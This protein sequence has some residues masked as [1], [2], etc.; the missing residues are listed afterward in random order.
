MA[1]RNILF[2]LLLIPSLLFA[3]GPGPCTPTLINNKLTGRR[4]DLRPFCLLGTEAQLC[5]GGLTRVALEE[6]SYVVNSSQGGG[7]KDT[8]VM[9]D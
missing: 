5:P 3:Q 9:S 2:L 4:V 7:V 1:V 6:G 8:W